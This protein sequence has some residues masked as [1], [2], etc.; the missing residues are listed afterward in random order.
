MLNEI[1][2]LQINGE[3][4]G[5]SLWHIGLGFTPWYSP[6]LFL[7]RGWCRSIFLGFILPQK[8]QPWQ[9]Q[10]GFVAN[11]TADGD[12]GEGSEARFS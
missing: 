9:R 12:A 3:H 4:H 10:K 11:N 7:F 5:V 2:I 1:N 8:K 6:L